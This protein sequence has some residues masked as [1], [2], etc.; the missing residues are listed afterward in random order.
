[1]LYLQLL[2]VIVLLGLLLKS[3]DGVPRP[4]PRRVPRRLRLAAA[5]TLFDSSHGDHRARPWDGRHVNG[6]FA[7]VP[8]ALTLA[9]AKSVRRRFDSVS[10]QK[11]RRQ[12]PNEIIRAG[13]NGVFTRRS[14]LMD[15]R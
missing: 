9:A 14:R 5:A 15:G 12:A 2:A 3:R 8:F 10:G 6:A 11:P 4:M 7:T 13:R 1:M